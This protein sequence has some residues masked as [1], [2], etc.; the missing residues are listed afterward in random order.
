MAR[1]GLSKDI[2]VQVLGDFYDVKVEI[3]EQLTW[4]TQLWRGP[5]IS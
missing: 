3:Q 4:I 2:F 5:E 1:I